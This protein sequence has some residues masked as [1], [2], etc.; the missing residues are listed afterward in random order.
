M[1]ARLRAARGQ[2]GFALVAFVLI[3]ATMLSLGLV[4]LGIVDSQ[5]RAS[6]AERLGASAFTLAEG[7][8][9]A[10]AAMVSSA[11][12]ESSGLAFSQSCTQ[13]SAGVTGCPSPGWIAQSFTGGDYAGATWRTDVRDDG[14]SYGAFWD[15][16]A[17]A[18]QPAWD[19]NG[20]GQV[21]VR[22][23]ATVGGRT[24]TLVERIQVN[25]PP[26]LPQGYAIIAGRF[27]TDLGVA[28]NQVVAS[29][30]LSG[31]MG[32][33]KLVAGGK[34]GLRCGLLSGCL[35]GT[36]AVLD[37]VGLD[38]LMANDVVQ[39]ASIQAASDQIVTELR[40][41]ALAAGTYYANVAAGTACPSPP[42]GTTSAIVFIEQVGNGDQACTVTLSS[43]STPQLRALVVASGRVT[44]AGTGTYK[45]I[46][47]AL[48]AQRA[49]LGDTPREVV[50]IQDS[51]RIDGMVAVDGVGG[52]VG[53]YPP[54]LDPYALI[55]TLPVCGTLTALLCAP[56]KASLQALSPDQLVVQLVSLVGLDAVV[57]GLLGQLSGYG[58]A[59]QYDASVVSALLADGTG[60]VVA[61]SFREIP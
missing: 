8:L 28:L 3:V 4:T 60:G 12:P 44:F 40:Q 55:N 11:W 19:Q 50:R 23:Q 54:P 27:S 18:S 34:V 47:W 51:A 25:R 37:E 26:A 38:S 33:H 24:R 10:Q 31:I 45:G 16:G 1:R 21:W 32:A 7:A 41:R 5:S 42:A 15:D 36:F 52:A 22:A 35:T 14:G 49:G 61:N 2:R 29:P 6:G 57:N 43:S 46:V 30:L 53:I 48:D 59:V 20:D 58:P 56:L 9:G 39:Y 17:L 13:A